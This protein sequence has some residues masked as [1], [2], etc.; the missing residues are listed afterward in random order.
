[1]TSLPTP[2]S[3]SAVVSTPRKRDERSR[4]RGSWLWALIKWTG[5]WGI[6]CLIFASQN[7]LRYIMRGQPVDWFA[8]IGMEALYWVPWLAL[9]PILLWTARN[10]PLG[11]GAPRANTF[12]H[13]GVM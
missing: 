1:M 11:S 2:Q 10:K 6:G 8:S 12:W 13:I 7:A 4:L 5:I 9:T 3:L